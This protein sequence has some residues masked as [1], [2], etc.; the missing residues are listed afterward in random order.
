MDLTLDNDYRPSL[1]L[2]ALLLIFSTLS[3]CSG[4]GERTDRQSEN[5][6]YTSEELIVTGMR[7]FAM[8]CA[9]CHGDARTGA[10]AYAPNPALENIGDKLT[11][12]ELRYIIRGGKGIMP[13][14]RHLSDEETDGLI[15]Y[16]TAEEVPGSPAMSHSW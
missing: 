10:G 8:N 6:T 13:P 12:E 7:V 14:F 5:S 3:A 4:D 11:D 15:L 9:A 16:L 1:L 2:T